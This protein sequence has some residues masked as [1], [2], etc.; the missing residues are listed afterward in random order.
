MSYKFLQFKKL[1]DQTKTGQKIKRIRSGVEDKP[2][3]TVVTQ[4]KK[5][6]A[7]VEDNRLKNIK[8]MPGEEDK[9]YLRRV[10]RM[11][12]ES[13]KEAQYEAKYGVKVIRN[14]KTGEIAIKKKPP[15]EI[16]ELLKQRRRGVKGG[17][18][19][20]KGINNDVKPLNL[21]LVKELVKQAIRED[22]EEKLREKDKEIVEFKTD[23]VK[24]GEIVHAP[25]ILSTLPRKAQRNETV[26]RVTN[27][28]L[29]P[30][31]SFLVCVLFSRERKTIFYLK[32]Y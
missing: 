1:A 22:D 14:P 6:N 10:N 4:N 12:T 30:M 18:I 9:E 24:F 23:V 7:Q 15:N 2:K 13:L 26:P 31:H 20:K 28:V 8:R 21:Q 32:V 19:D 27:L 17:K 5:K 29:L 25:P 3:H 16:D 11:T